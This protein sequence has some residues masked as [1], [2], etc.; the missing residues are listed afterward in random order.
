MS[1]EIKNIAEL[2]I[3]V[4]KPTEAFVEYE[5][6]KLLSPGENYGSVMLEIKLKIRKENDDHEVLN[7]VAK[8]CPTSP[9]LR[10]IFN[11]KVTFKKEIAVYTTIAPLLINFCKTK[12]ADSLINF[13][14]KLIGARLSLNPESSEVDEDA[15]LL[16]ENLNMEGYNTGN[17]FVGFD[18]ETTKY[19]LRDLAVMHSTAIAYRTA[20]PE[21]FNLKI[22]PYLKRDLNSKAVDKVIDDFAKRFVDAAEQ[23]PDCAPFLSKIKIAL[24][25]MKEVTRNPPKGKDIFMTLT[26]N[27]F[28]VNNTMLKYNEGKPIGNKI[29]D[30]QM[31]EYSSLANDVI[32]FLYSS[33]ELSVLETKID[34]LIQYYYDMFIM[35]LVKLGYNIS[36][37]SFESMMEDFAYIANK[38]QF[39][40]IL[41]LL[42]PIMKLKTVQNSQLK[43]DD[44]ANSDR[45]LHENYYGK[46]QFVLSDF[47]KRGWI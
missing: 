12:G 22:L 42:S 46:L 35:T 1:I 40:H 36:A 27:D 34:E 8:I 33:V 9:E 3:P 29:I 37:Y 31:I 23:N 41:Y 24:I 11:T 30:F 10:E 14:T 5:S 28:W 26:H 21:E 4:L 45:I 17:R 18:E 13:F 25:E 39:T 16:L 44:T 6:N 43:T 38:C 15:V 7:C 2:V 19:L 20:H 47:D 32:F